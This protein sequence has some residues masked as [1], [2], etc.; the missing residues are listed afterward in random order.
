M[1]MRLLVCVTTILLAGTAWAQGV[2]NP[3]CANQPKECCQVEGGLLGYECS[4]GGQ[5][6]FIIG[7]GDELTEVSG[8]NASFSVAGLTVHT[9]IGNTTFAPF[10]IGSSEKRVRFTT[11]D[12]G[13]CVQVANLSGFVNPSPIVVEGR[14]L[15][16][17][18]TGAFFCREP[19]RDLICFPV[20]GQVGPPFP[21]NLSCTPD[22][23]EFA[24]G[25][26][27]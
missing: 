6:H 19:Q 25:L 20:K 4:G 8:L 15:T 22:R 16:I 2:C 11:S 12:G 7:D 18:K 24:C 23:V 1:R 21:T 5:P 10:K 17:L 14:A 26:V 3:V 9:T 13:E 27:S